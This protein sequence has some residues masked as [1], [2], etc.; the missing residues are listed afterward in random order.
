MASRFLCIILVIFTLN[1]SAEENKDLSSMTTPVNEPQRQ[2]MLINPENGYE[3]NQITATVE[4]CPLNSKKC[5]ALGNWTF[6][7]SKKMIATDAMNLSKWL[8]LNRFNAM[9]LTDQ[10]IRIT[11]PYGQVDVNS[12]GAVPH[13]GIETLAEFRSSFEKVLA[14]RYSGI[15]TSLDKLVEIRA[16]NLNNAKP[17]ST[18]AGIIKNKV[19]DSFAIENYVQAVAAKISISE[20]EEFNSETRR[21]EIHYYVSVNPTV[22][23]K[24]IAYDFN[25]ESHSFKPYK[26]WDGTSCF[27]NE[28]LT[29][30]DKPARPKDIRE[31]FD[32]A[33]FIAYKA[34]VLDQSIQVKRDEHF[35]LKTKITEVKDHYFKSNLNDNMDLRIDSLWTISRFF[36]GEMHQVGLGKTLQVA[37]SPMQGEQAYSTFSNFKGDVAQGDQLKEFPSSGVKYSFGLANVDYQIKELADGAS[38]ITSSVANQSLWGLKAGATRDLGYLYNSDLLSDVWLTYNVTY[39]K[40]GEFYLNSIKIV[41][42]DFYSVDFCVEKTFYLGRSGILFSPS[43]GIGISEFKAGGTDGVTNDDYEIKLDQMTLK[44]SVSLDYIL[45]NFNDFRLNLE[46]PLQIYNAGT[47]SNQTTSTD[48]SLTKN[49]S[50]QGLSLYLTYRWNIDS[51]GSLAKDMK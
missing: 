16:K 6:H 34:A 20:V 24:L 1:S 51:I 2:V 5:E 19:T 50:G 35:T 49:K 14:E 39:A 48:F 8:G 18:V 12:P 38:A 44:P 28:S 9:T 7:I 31:L 17:E 40:G 45:D 13:G 21:K 36:N 37:S 11:S 23:A 10:S 25:I 42:P 32:A 3:S 43:I 26:E 46:Y 22:N 41:S 29:Y 15:A 47:F 33:Y 30:P 27:V 4:F